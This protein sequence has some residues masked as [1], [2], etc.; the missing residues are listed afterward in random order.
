MT[1]GRAARA[2]G[3]QPPCA[4]CA[5]GAGAAEEPAADGDAA[6]GSLLFSQ[7]TRGDAMADKARMRRATEVMAEDR[8][9]MVFANRSHF[10]A[11]AKPPGAAAC[12]IDRAGRALRGV[13]IAHCA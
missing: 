11:F 4:G 9:F 2:N 6:G 10:A 7:P 13:A 1:V 5:D 3:Y 8:W 12:A